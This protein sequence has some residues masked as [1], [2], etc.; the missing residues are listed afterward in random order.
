MRIEETPWPIPYHIRGRERPSWDDYFRSIALA[1]AQR[2]DCR[3][4]QAGCVI[5][6]QDHRVIGTGFNGAEPGGPSCLAGEC[7]RGLLSY[8]E[9]AEHGS[10]DNC[11]ATHAEVN[12]LLFARTSCKGATAYVTSKPCPTCEKALRSAGIERIV[13][14]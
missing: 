12:A 1:V 3:R 13:H 10:Y 8:A 4:R 14:N 6:D 9:L 5:V 2:A 7:P 11:V